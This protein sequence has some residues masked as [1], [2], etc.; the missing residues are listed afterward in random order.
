MKRH[1]IHS[2]EEEIMR[3]SRFVSALVIATVAAGS[4]LATPKAASADEVS[5]CARLEAIRINIESSMAPSFAKELAIAAI[6]GTK[7]AAACQE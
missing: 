4:L 5:F 7:K 3:K 2:P 1:P 6:Y